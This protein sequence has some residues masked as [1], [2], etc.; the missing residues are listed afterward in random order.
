MAKIVTGSVKPIRCMGCL[1]ILQVIFMDTTQKFILF[2]LIAFSFGCTGKTLSEARGE[3]ANQVSNPLIRISVA[4]AETRQ[5]SLS[6]QATGSLI[7]FE[8]SNVAP[9]VSGKVS[10]IYVEIGQFVQAGSIIA[11]LDDKEA[12]LRLAEAEAS[13][14]QAEA[15][16]RQAEARLGLTPNS[17]FNASEIP[18]VRLANA[19][20]EQSLAELRQAEANEKRYRELL[21]TGDVARITY[22]QY[23]TALDTARARANAAKQAL[24]AAINQA[25]QNHQAIKSAQAAVEAAKAQA[26]TY[27]QALEDT[28]IRAPFS[29]FIAEKRVAVGEYVT[30]ATPIVTLVRTNPI[31]VQIQTPESNVP[32]ISIGSLVSVEIDAYKDRKFVGSVT[33]IKP[34]I[35]PSSRSAIVEAQIENAENLLKPG[36]FANVRINL[37]GTETAIFVPKSAV[38]NDKVTQ[39]YRVFVI[40][41]NVARLRVVQLGSEEDT[42]I[43]I[44]SGVNP[45]EIVATSNLDQLYEGAKVEF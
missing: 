26:E 38:Y 41:E 42:M 4:K 15:S 28:I 33:A 24:E 39:S 12:R 11:K 3:N 7:A 35:D 27:R 22:E 16:V 31:K 32:F 23:R 40:Q 37:K 25:K 2:V 21:E 43:Q 18:E 9:K 5:V 8:Q 1:K 17:N 6:I 34:S 30:S 45:E 13:I 29:G 44:L 19:N 36:M 10:N 20:Y 14:K